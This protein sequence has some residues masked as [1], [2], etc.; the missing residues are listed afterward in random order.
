MKIIDDI[1][2]AQRVENIEKNIH[3][4][5]E[6]NN[7]PTPTAM[8]KEIGVAPTTWH[9]FLKNPLSNSTAKAAFCNYFG[10][11]VKRLENER[12]TDLDLCRQQKA[13]D[14]LQKKVIGFETQDSEENS[15]MEMPDD[16]IY[17][18]LRNSSTDD[19]VLSQE[20]QSLK[21]EIIA[22][23]QFRYKAYMIQ[24]KREYQNNNLQKALEFVYS[25]WWM[26]SKNELNV[27][28]EADLI[29]YITLCETQNDLLGIEKLV[30]KL[31]SKDFFVPKIV[32]VL[33]TLLELS[34]PELAKKCYVTVCTMN[35]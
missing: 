9:S 21:N 2:D 22:K 13:V 14:L 6:I 15:I 19:M 10:V 31:T 20:I 35:T 28:T 29:F 33:G 4:A 34:F 12:L 26:L 5:S 32:L 11:T 3:L 7:I 8:A 25:A 24:A 1:S 17:E 18:K 16:V 27:V 30:D 23:N